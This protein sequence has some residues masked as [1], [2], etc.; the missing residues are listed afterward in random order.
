M[1]RR[2]QTIALLARIGEDSSRRRALAARLDTALKRAGISSACAAR[3]LD[4]CERDVQFWRR[5]ITVPPPNAFTRIAAFLNLDAS[6]LC[7]GQS[8]GASAIL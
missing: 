6:W 1:N 2:A 3:R 5:G 7:T 4:M 8:S